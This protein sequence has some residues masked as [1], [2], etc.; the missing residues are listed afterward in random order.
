M[1]CLLSILEKIIDRKQLDVIHALASHH[2]YR[3][4]AL[5]RKITYKTLV[6][7][8]IISWNCILMFIVE[9]VIEFALLFKILSH[10]PF[11][12]NFLSLTALSVVLAIQAIRGVRQGE[13]ELTGNALVMSAAVELLL[14]FGDIVYLVQY[15]DTYPLVVKIRIPFMI[16]TSINFCLVNFLAFHTHWVSRNRLQR[17]QRKT[18]RS[19]IVSHRRVVEGNTEVLEIAQMA[20]TKQVASEDS[21]EDSVLDM[22][23]TPV[24]RDKKKCNFEEILSDEDQRGNTNHNL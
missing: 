23:V 16:L 4:E 2:A 20:T 8:T 11:R 13:I 6:A 18:R 17:T 10:I 1:G 22:A 12:L 7:T 3:Q 24:G 15:A 5:T 14:I 19:I 21:I 9:V